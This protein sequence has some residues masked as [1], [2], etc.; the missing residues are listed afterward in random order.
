[1]TIGKKMLFT[2]IL[3]GCFIVS[4]SV[5]AQTVIPVDTSHLR[6]LRI[7]PENA[8]GGTAKEIFQSAEYI[9]LETTKE[10][11]FGDIEQLEVTKDRFIILD[12]STNC[13]LFFD[14]KG[15]FIGKIKGG[16]KTD[17]SNVIL[18]FTFNKWKKEVVFFQ[19]NL[20]SRKF[21]YCNLDGQKIRELPYDINNVPN[22]WQQQF[23]APDL[24]VGI[25]YYQDKQKVSSNKLYELGFSERFKK[26]QATAIPTSA[27]RLDNEG[28]Y[29]DV[30]HNFSYAGNDSTF[31]FAKTHDYNLYSITPK[32]VSHTF[33]FLFPMQMALPKNFMTDAAY[34]DKK[35]DFISKGPFI[36]M[37]NDSYLVGSNL[38]F[39]LPISSK[40][41]GLSHLIYNL[42]S[43]K[44]I[45]YKYISTD[46]STYYLP[47]MAY[48]RYSRGFL[49]CDGKSMFMQ[50]S[51]NVMFTEME[52]NKDKGVT[53]SPS[54]QQYFKG[55]NRDN[56]VIL[57]VTLKD[58]L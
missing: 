31:F 18:D 38:T 39:N 6:T 48:Y 30:L 41:D 11:L 8:Y 4:N 49:G 42:K 47:L 23:V 19:G 27:A 25:N 17:Y 58:N 13:I 21:V 3:V 37:I 45:S 44:L 14:R 10:S 20:A 33:R 46:E 26:I 43:D 34:K 52:N 57:Q 51:S 24:L 55:S 54:L 9:P 40:R 56:P 36:Q 53:Y 5:I 7:D 32:T 22:F 15:K 35:L 1:M 2:L 28:D 16:S 29:Y 50:L 12:R